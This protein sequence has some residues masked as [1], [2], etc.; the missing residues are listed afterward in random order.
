[1]NY[2]AIVEDPVWQPESWTS[3]ADKQELVSQFEGWDPIVCDLIA[4]TNKDEYFKWDLLVRKPLQYRSSDRITLLGDAAHPM[5]PYLA[6]GA[7]MA[8][9]DD[10]VFAHIAARYDDAKSSLLAYE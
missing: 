5:V 9:E 10:W 8:M 4:Q 7:V 1:M 6:Q 2:F 3:L